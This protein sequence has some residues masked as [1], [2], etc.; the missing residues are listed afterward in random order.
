MA[1]PNWPIILLGG[2]GHA[3]VLVEVLLLHHKAVLGYTSLA[4]GTTN[5]PNLLRLGDDRIIDDHDPEK[6]AL[7]NGI[8]SVKSTSGRRRIFEQFQR[9]RY[10]FASVIHPAAT[11]ATDARLLEGVQVMAGAV[12]Q[13]GVLLG[14]NAIVNTGA[15]ID[16]DCEIGAHAHIAPGAVLSGGVHIAEGAHVGTGALVIQGVRIGANSVVGAGAVVLKDVPAGVTVVG[17]PGRI[18]GE[19]IG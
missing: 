9:K 2:G 11:I 15:V 17:V 12:V 10:R 3:K 8:G 7:V 19:S 13:P 16:H 18:I 6:I 4:S 5:I 14:G 1:E